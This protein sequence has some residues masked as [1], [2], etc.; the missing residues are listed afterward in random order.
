MNNILNVGEILYV[1]D[2]KKGNG[3]SHDKG[4]IVLFRNKVKKRI[5]KN[6][7]SSQGS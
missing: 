3:V 2:G 7:Q 4:K 5:C 1:K 6:N